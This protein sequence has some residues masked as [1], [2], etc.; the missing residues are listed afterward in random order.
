[1]KVRNLTGRSVLVDGQ[2]FAPPGL[3]FVSVKDT[4][5]VQALIAAGV[6]EVERD[7]KSDD[8]NKSSTPTGRK[9]APPKERA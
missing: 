4:E 9:A 8:D 1:M 3:D 6:L 7:N 5:A 2:C